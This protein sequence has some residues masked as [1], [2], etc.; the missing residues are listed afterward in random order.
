MH[1]AMSCVLYM[2]VH[3]CRCMYECQFVN[4]RVQEC[5]INNLINHVTLCY[6]LIGHTALVGNTSTIIHVL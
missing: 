4:F 1:N 6:N 5:A 2:Y 3:V